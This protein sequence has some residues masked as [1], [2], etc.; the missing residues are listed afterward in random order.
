MAFA[1]A[2]LSCRSSAPPPP[3][4]DDPRYLCRVDVTPLRAAL[5]ASGGDPAR[6]VRP[7]D[8]R[9]LLSLA[10]GRRFKFVLTGAGMFAVAPMPSDAAHSEYVHPVLGDGAPVRSA[11]GVTVTHDDGRVSRVVLDAE[12]RAYCTTAESLRPAVRALRAMGVPAELIAVEARPFACVETGAPPPRY[13]AVMLGVGRR[14]ETL[15]RAIAAGRWEL[16]DHEVEELAE[17]AGELPGATPPPSVQVDLAALARAFPREHLAPLT[18]AVARRDSAAATAT[19][20][21]AAG[22][23]NACHRTAGKSGI[24]VSTTPGDA[25]P[26]ITPAAR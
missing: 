22:A 5:R 1:L 8:Q 14:F 16:A 4:D 20:A 12:S 17:D 24:M 7:T 21:A 10:S 13:G 23:C 26:W 18:A 2:T 6:I 9:G 11:G 19:Y 3:L 15:G 25:V